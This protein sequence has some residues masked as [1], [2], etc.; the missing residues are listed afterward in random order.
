MFPVKLE[1]LK[2]QFKNYQED[3]GLNVSFADRDRT[4][5]FV[6]VSLDKAKQEI[7]S[8]REF[9]SYCRAL[10]LIK[11]YESVEGMGTR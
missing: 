10:G 7:W 4:A 9:V 3:G 1:E 5:P 8:A 11:W 2:E 6:T